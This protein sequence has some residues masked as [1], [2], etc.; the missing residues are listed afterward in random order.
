MFTEII[1]DQ[2]PH[3]L[4]TQK[5]LGFKRERFSKLAEYLDIPQIIAITGVRR[6]GKSTLLKQTI[7]YLIDDLDINPENILFLNLEQPYLLQFTQDIQN[8][9]K[10]FQE[11][12][13]LKN[14]SGKLY[15][16]LD[17]IQ[18]FANWPVFV[19]SHY[20][21]KNVKFLITG[22]NSHLLSSEM[23]TLLSGRALPLELYP[24]SFK[25]IVNTN[26]IAYHKENERI[27][28]RNT[29]KNLLNQML[30][31]GGFPEILFIDNPQL[32]T[33]ILSNYAK[34]IV[35]QDIAPRLNLRKAKQLEELFLYLAT[36]ISAI[37]SY[38]KLS[39]YFS[40]SDKSIKEYIQAFSD[41]YLILELER[42]SYSVKPNFK[43]F[44]KTY[45]IDCGMANACGFKFA[46]NNGKLLEN[47]IFIDYKQRNLEVFFYKTKNNLEVDFIL[48][49]HN[50]ITPV[51]IA[52]QIDNKK[53]LLREVTALSVALDE[54]N[55]EKGV[56]VTAED[57]IPYD[58]EDHRIMHV[59]A[60]EW[61]LR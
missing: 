41:A 46:K 29:L 56:I 61:L 35:L 36:N 17:E 19:K 25:E 22:S 47:L 21:N 14:P 52:W 26:N 23:I 1:V 60:Y 37:T 42:F 59:S 9:E 33:D 24:L 48:K 10:I 45:M 57:S 31:K 54:L 43:T 12:L 11:Y 6:C 39:S 51:Q 34:T 18:F 38:N 44:K 4:G 30:D 13:R 49:D 15:V 58:I 55:L 2:N 8:L 3:W 28:A 32:Y 53:T 27:A 16:L 40:L 5:P 50:N 7:N 20:E